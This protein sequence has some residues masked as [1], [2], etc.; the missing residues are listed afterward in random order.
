MEAQDGNIGH[1]PQAGAWGQ[2]PSR[3]QSPYGDGHPKPS[4][5]R[6]QWRP[7]PQVP[8]GR[9]LLGGLSLR[10]DRPW[11]HTSSR[12]SNKVNVPIAPRWLPIAL[13]HGS[14]VTPVLATGEVMRSAVVIAMPVFSYILPRA[15]KPT[16]PFVPIGVAGVSTP[17]YI[18]VMWRGQGVCSPVRVSPPPVPHV[19]SP[20][21]VPARVA[22]VLAI[23]GA[24]AMIKGS[25]GCHR[26][27][28]SSLRGGGH[29]CA[30]WVSWHCSRTQR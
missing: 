21:R 25:T 4:R 2:L 9:S 20:A 17:N 24:T 16:G 29:E 28:N 27:G 23:M 6:Q 15:H 12:H 26:H 22:R 10:V 30:C 3:A 8:K 14:G 1:V 7:L 19:V 11:T 13:P 18:L 5:H